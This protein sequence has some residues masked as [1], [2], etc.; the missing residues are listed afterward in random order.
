MEPIDNQSLPTNCGKLRTN[1][2][3]IVGR[4]NVNLYVT[5]TKRWNM[6]MK[7]DS[8]FELRLNGDVK[9]AAMNRAKKLGVSLAE[10]INR[11][12]INDLNTS[13]EQ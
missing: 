12:L 10:L 8:R 6:E 1:S 2:N 3:S 9:V 11:L 7:R 13:V 4:K 5:T